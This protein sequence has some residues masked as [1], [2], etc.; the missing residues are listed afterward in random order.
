MA[1]NLA[2]KA[3]IDPEVLTRTYV[4]SSLQVDQKTL[5]D[6]YAFFSGKEVDMLPYVYAEPSDAYNALVH[7]PEYYLFRDEVNT[8]A[9][10][11]DVLRRYLTG[12]T[13]IVEI[14]PGCDYT[15]ENKTVPI[16]NCASDLKRYHAIDYSENY[17][18]EACRSVSE[19]KSDIEVLGIEADLM[20]GK[21]D[22]GKIPL[23][24]KCIL[25]LGSTLG[26]F[27][28]MQ[29]QHAI[30]QI[31]NT[32]SLGEML[33]LTVDTNYHGESVLSSY[34]N[35]SFYAFAM[36]SLNNL[37]TIYPPFKKY[38]SSFEVR[39]VWDEANNLNNAYFITKNNL[40]FE[41][42][43]FGI[44]NITS[45][46]KLE[47]IKSRKFSRNKIATLLKNTFDIIDVLSYSQKAQVFICKR[48]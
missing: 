30:S 39:C 26:N 28:E 20:N 24:K 1:S 11:Q 45:G 15:V 25:F 47:G 17:L 41:F 19:R 13:D 18:K 29:Q 21:I 35:K 3:E 2:H 40:S 6:Y 38:L 37:A 27:T 23:G 22:L 43:N 7:A 8:I 9:N 32:T 46:Q 31:A 42:A 16:L 44:I 5:D 36:N 33:I 12:V 10:N 34:S 14:G 4:S 48:I